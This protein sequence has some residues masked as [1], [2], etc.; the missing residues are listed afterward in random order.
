MEQLERLSLPCSAWCSS[1]QEELPG[2]DDTWYCDHANGTRA[3]LRGH[4]RPSH[5]PFPGMQHCHHHWAVLAA[6]AVIYE[7]N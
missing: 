4:L 1:G 7:I 3:E 5:V 2:D 6:A